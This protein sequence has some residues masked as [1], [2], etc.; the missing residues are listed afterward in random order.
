MVLYC[1]LS[2][3]SFLLVFGVFFVSAPLVHQAL[4]IIS[5]A[6][7]RTNFFLFSHELYHALHEGNIHFAFPFYMLLSSDCLNLPYIIAKLSSL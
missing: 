3:S 4:C 2:G 1:S 7:Y 6:I 5:S